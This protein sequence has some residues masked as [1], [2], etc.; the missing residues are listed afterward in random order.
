VGNLP[1]WTQVIAEDFLS[2]FNQGDVVVNTNGDLTSAGAAFTAYG[3][4]LQVFPYQDTTKHKTDHLGKFNPAILSC[5]GSRTTEANGAISINMRN[6]LVAGV[7]TGYGSTLKLKRPD[8]AYRQL[9]GK[10]RF[11]MKV[12]AVG[13]APNGFVVLMEGIDSR[14]AA[15]W[16]GG[17]FGF[18]ENGTG[19]GSTW[20]GWYHKKGT[21]TPPAQTRVEGDGTLQSAY[22]IHDW[23]WT[24]G[25]F[26]WTVNGKVFLDTTDSVPDTVMELLAQCEPDAPLGAAGNTA[27]VTIDWWCIYDYTP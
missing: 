26:V 27:Q 24:P 10:M 6:E 22:A 20:K 18:P 16:A 4:K 1:G 5:D 3:T 7:L 8:G 15:A 9:Y 17:E 14:S 2:S 11:R 19:V 13:T 21:I 23:Q 12:D 25:H